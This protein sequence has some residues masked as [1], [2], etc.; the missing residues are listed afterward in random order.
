MPSTKV[1]LRNRWMRVSHRRGE[2][3]VARAAAVDGCYDGVV[4][5]LRRLTPEKRRR[6]VQDFFE[7][8]TNGRKLGLL[9]AGLIVLDFNQRAPL[10]KLVQP[11]TDHLEKLGLEAAPMK[12]VVPRGKRELDPDW[13]DAYAEYQRQAPPEGP[14]VEFLRQSV[15]TALAA[16]PRTVGGIR[17]VR[18]V[19]RGLLVRRVWGLVGEQASPWDPLAEVVLAGWVPVGLSVDR[20]FLV[21]PLDERGADRG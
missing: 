11:V 17:A 1:E 4:A 7:S 16:V 18:T 3:E 2:P 14:L 6:L 20:E 21:A 13:A 12:E 5:S 8:F 15:S 19:P 10:Q 9:A